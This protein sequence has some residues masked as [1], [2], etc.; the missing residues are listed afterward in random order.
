MAANVPDKNAVNNAT[1]SAAMAEL[2]DRAG[3]G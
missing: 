2:S 3:R 1:P